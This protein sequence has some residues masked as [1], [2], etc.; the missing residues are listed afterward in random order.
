MKLEDFSKFRHIQLVRVDLVIFG[1]VYPDSG[2]VF[3][4]GN[5]F[6][7]YPD[8]QSGFPSVLVWP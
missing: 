5:K 6:L 4:V 2:L 3:A 7:V 1:L 8:L